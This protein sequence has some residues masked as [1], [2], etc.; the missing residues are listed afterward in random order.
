MKTHS[1]TVEKRRPKP[2]SD[3][4]DLI[5]KIEGDRS[6]VDVFELSRVLDSIGTIAKESYRVAHPDEGELKLAIKPFKEGSFI[7]DIALQLQQNP[8]ILFVL[9]HPE[10]RDNLKSTLEGLPI[11]SGKKVNRRQPQGPKL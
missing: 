8:A 3:S 7:M 4:I 9:T 10:V 6:E 11:F 2:S 5:Y 1:T